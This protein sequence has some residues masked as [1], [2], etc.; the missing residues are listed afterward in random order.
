M[1][2]ISRNSPFD[3]KDSTDITK[4]DGKETTEVKS[5]TTEVPVFE[6][7]VTTVKATTL[8]RQTTSVRPSINPVSSL[9]SRITETRYPHNPRTTTVT[10]LPITYSEEFVTEEQEPTQIESN[11][12]D[13]VATITSPSKQSSAWLLF[14]L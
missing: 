9:I 2:S 5:A 10:E 6:T 1:A 14:P 11:Y 12:E 8:V 3:Y 7:E 13:E 4:K